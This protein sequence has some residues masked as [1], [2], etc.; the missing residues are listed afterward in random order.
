MIDV[1]ATELLMVGLP[2][3]NEMKCKSY[4]KLGK[5]LFVENGVFV[6]MKSFDVLPLNGLHSNL[7]TITRT[8]P[9]ISSRKKKA[10][11]SPNSE[12]P[13]MHTR[14]IYNP[15]FSL[16]KYCAPEEIKRKE[17]DYDSIR[18]TNHKQS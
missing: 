10:W 17:K 12:P 15:T 1:V 6:R 4:M 13:T 11:S 14:K 5:L 2:T 16:S 7:I 9:S 18:N 3:K 8:H